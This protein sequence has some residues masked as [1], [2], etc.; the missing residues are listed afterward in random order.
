M[1]LPAT[2]QDKIAMYAHPT[3][4]C[5]TDIN[6]CSYEMRVLHC[7]NP[8]SFD[9]AIAFRSDVCNHTDLMWKYRNFQLHSHRRRCHRCMKKTSLCIPHGNGGSRHICGPCFRHGTGFGA[10][11][12]NL[13]HA[14]CLSTSSL[15]HRT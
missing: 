7:Q 2:I 11:G 9:D 12:E 15:A 8:F 6:S 3:H 13:G 10:S 14:H 1:Y 5:L 4:P